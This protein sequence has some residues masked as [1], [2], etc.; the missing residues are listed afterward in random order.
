MKYHARVGDRGAQKEIGVRRAIG[1]RKSDI[2]W[3]F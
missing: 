2:I 3:Q 1:A